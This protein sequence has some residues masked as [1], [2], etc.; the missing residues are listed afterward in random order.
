MAT[1]SKLNHI[2]EVNGNS[3][4]PN[5]SFISNKKETNY[6]NITIAFLFSTLQLGL[7]NLILMSVVFCANHITLVVHH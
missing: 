4:R 2:D 3:K 5:K 1:I 6:K 7:L